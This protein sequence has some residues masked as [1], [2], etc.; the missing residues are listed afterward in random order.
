VVY[1]IRRESD[2]LY[3]LGGAHLTPSQPAAVVG[4]CLL[5]WDDRGKIW[6]SLAEVKKHIMQHPRSEWSEWTVEKYT[7]SMD[8]A[9]AAV[10]LM[11]DRVE[12]PR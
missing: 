9:T 1:K 6:H 8:N 7:L 2:G 4:M 12:E 5:K 11:E 10:D 3:S